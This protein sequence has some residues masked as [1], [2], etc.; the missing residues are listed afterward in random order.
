MRS[1][2]D[3]RTVI[4]STLTSNTSRTLVQHA[5]AITSRS[6]AFL[7]ARLKALG[8]KIIFGSKKITG[9]LSK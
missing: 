5:A 2:T 9:P 4:D 6:V 7:R 8:Q 3:A 1:K